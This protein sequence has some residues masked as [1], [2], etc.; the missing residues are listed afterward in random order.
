MAGSNHY[1]PVPVSM[2]QPCTDAIN[3]INEGDYER[4]INLP[5]GI[6]YRGNTAAPAWSIAEAHHLDAFLEVEDD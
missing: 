1:P 5:D 2:I 4:E 3:A 6:S